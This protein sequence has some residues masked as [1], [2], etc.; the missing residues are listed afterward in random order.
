M[1]PE[2]LKLLPT[3]LALTL[4]WKEGLQ[5]KECKEC[6]SRSWKRW[7]DRLS[8]EPL[9]GAQPRGHL[10]FSPVTP[11]SDIRPPGL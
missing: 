7:G 2:R 9:E 3:V 1:E 6:S 5:V 11:I 4:G 8:L 10:A